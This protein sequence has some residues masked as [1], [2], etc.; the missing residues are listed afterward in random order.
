MGSKDASP[1]GH[2]LLAMSTIQKIKEHFESGKTLTAC[3]AAQRFLTPDLRKYV[4]DLRKDK[5]PI[6]DR[7]ETSQKGKRY[8][9]YFLNNGTGTVSN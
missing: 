1:G 9:I 3:E 8:K 4:S 7:W 5:V 2:R 6:D